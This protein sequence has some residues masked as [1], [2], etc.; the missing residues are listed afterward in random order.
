MKRAGAVI[1][2]ILLFSLSLAV[3]DVNDSTTTTTT[4][5]TTI[6]APNQSRIDKAFT[7]LDN[8]VKGNCNQLSI[9]EMAL[10]VLASPT[11]STQECLDALKSKK[12]AEN[13][14][15]DSA[16]TVRDTALA[17]LALNHAGETTD[18]SENWLLNKTK[19][20]TDL[21]W[22][23][24]QDS[25]EAT[26]CAVSYSSKVYNIRVADNKK[27]D[28]SAGNCLTLAQSN[29]W[30]QVSPSCYNDEFQ[31]TCDK[32]FIATLLYRQQN[33]PTIYVLSDTPSAAA[34]SPI[35]LKIKAKCF[36]TTN[37]C[38]YEDSLWATFALLQTGHEVADFLPYVI[39]L[40]DSNK[41]FMPN[42]F[43][44]II[45]QDTDF[46][47]QLVQEQKLGNFWLADN[48]AYNKLY[49]T[50][51]ALLALEES[52]TDQ[53]ARAKNYLLSD[54]AQDTSG[55]WKNSN[56]EKIRDTALILWS[57]EHRGGPSVSSGISR[58]T[59]SDYF[60]VPVSD[61]PT[62]QRLDNYFCS[63]SGDSCCQ[64]EN[65][66][67]CQEKGGS[68]CTTGNECSGLS[69]RTSD[70]DACCIG[71]SG[72]TPIVVLSECEQQEYLCQSSCN[73]NQ[74]EAD[75]SCSASTDTCCKLKTAP[76]TTSKSY[77]WLWILLII[78]IILVVLAI[79]FRDRVKLWWFKMKSK[80]KKEKGGSSTESPSMS[81]PGPGFPPRPGFPPLRRMP[82]PGRPPMRPMGQPIR[83]PA[84]NQAKDKGM[85]SVFQK[86]KEMSK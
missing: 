43:I 18:L 27:I 84:P 85:D 12:K 28:S 83:S 3:A 11:E 40:A 68:V 52:S 74:E 19:T 38:N 7:C 76:T 78:L 9:R 58:C 64:S 35:T 41:K 22:Y 79:I 17:V 67:T 26:T 8:L 30:L 23:L 82:P 51:L 53:V 46:G 45:N 86:L 29:F 75:Y 70:E 14:W 10:V 34:S 55:C 15:G 2:L 21:I 72:C 50:A 48:S 60:C 20:S 32:N 49:D 39:A 24:E 4:S 31:V 6:P 61:C 33:S 36:T 47:N 57:L 80:F 77:L 71:T 44:Y 65:L 63:G 66:E 62:A 13:C 42:A 69:V 37:Q 5:T 16:C 54:L 1:I 59:E 81:R 56:S 73:A 25:D